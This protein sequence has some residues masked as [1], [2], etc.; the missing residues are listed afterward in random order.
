MIRKKEILALPPVPAVKKGGSVTAQM[1]GGVLVLNC[2]Q[3]GDLLGRWCMDT[4]TGRYLTWKAETGEWEERKLMTVYEFQ[5]SWYSR[6]SWYKEEGGVE[7][8]TQQDQETMEKALKK[9]DWEKD[10]FRLIGSREEAYQS[11]RRDRAAEKKQERL[12]RQMESVPALPR[13]LR[14]WIHQVS[15]GEDYLFLAKGGKN[16][17]FCTACG[18]VSERKE[19]EAEKPK[20]GSAVTC[21]SCGRQIRY[22]G[23]KRLIRRQTHCILLHDMGEKESVARHIDVRITW[24]NTGRRAELSEGVRLVMYRKYKKRACEIY[25]SQ[26][27]KTDWPAFFLPVQNV[28][29]DRTN[30]ANRRIQ[31]GY[32]YPDGIQEALAGTKYEA[33]TSIFQ[34]AAGKGILMDYN[35]AMCATGN[36]YLIRT[37]EYLIKGRFFRLTAESVDRFSL[38]HGYRGPLHIGGED[39]REVFGIRDRQKINRI[40][41]MDG[42]ETAVKWMRESEASG[43]KISR[44]FFSWAQ[45]TGLAPGDLKGTGTTPEQAMH[46][47]RR[48]QEES[49][50]GKSGQEVLEQW[51][52]YLSMCRQ[53]KKEITDPMISR[54]RELKRRHDEAVE[55]IG[56]IRKLEEVKKNRKQAEELEQEMRKKYPGAEKNLE[57]IRNTYEYEDGEYRILVPKRLSE[58]ALEGCALH[59]CV[60][61]SERY[62]ERIMRHETYICFLRKTSEPEVPY[63]TI[64]VEPGGTIRQHR[65]MYDEEPDI[66]K[67]RGFLKKWQQVI[68]S[69]MKAE[70]HRRAKISRNLREDNLRQLKEANNTRVLAGLMEDFMEAAETEETSQE[71]I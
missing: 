47:M 60:G 56:T 30:Q 46:Y 62:Y 68:R 3:N 28:C 54:P 64:E 4:E 44:E 36:T 49:Y 34:E 25:Y 35:L 69:R 18:A 48:Q 7:F 52:D 71:A 22:A 50:P 24:D 65:S 20:E 31:P 61:S 32:L 13:G 51:Q 14:S 41:D 37:C 11:S 5:P 43:R 10:A 26:K 67:I 57:E 40:R 23:R 29:F 33:W 39:I 15:G 21:K 38:Y 2:Y 6:Y 8:D 19:P 66:E 1:A 45:E 58:I 59:H 53:L 16:R 12:E 9:R 63:Y 55:A 17:W 42:G 70:D 27:P